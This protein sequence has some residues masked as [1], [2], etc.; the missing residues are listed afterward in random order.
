[1]SETKIPIVCKDEKILYI[2]EG[3]IK[4][5]K[6]FQDMYNDCITKKIEPKITFPPGHIY[7]TKLMQHVI[8]YLEYHMDQDFPKIP[9]PLP[10]TGLKGCVSEWDYKFITSIEDDIDYLM[11]SGNPPMLIFLGIPDFLE[12]CC[13][14]FATIFVNGNFKE[15]MD[16]FHMEPKELTKKQEEDIRNS[17]EFQNI[18]KNLFKL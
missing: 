1:M 18:M 7:D 9:E 5:C 10:S 3:A 14:Y 16:F 2:K 13:A 8:D 17:K 6:Y 11:T 15:C 4:N 12:L